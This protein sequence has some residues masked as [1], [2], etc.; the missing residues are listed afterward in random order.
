[1]LTRIL[2]IIT[3]LAGCT[4][5]DKTNIQPGQRIQGLG[6][7][8]EAPSEKSW[9]ASVY[10]TG[11]EIKLNQLNFDD[12]YS[13]LVAMNRGPR[14]GMYKSAEQHLRALKQYHRQTRPPEGFIEKT[15]QEWI[16]SR[17]G[18]ICVRRY[19]IGE[20]WA[21]RNNAGP[22]IVETES[23]ICPHQSLRNVLVTVEL[24][25]RYEAYA[26]TVPLRPL[27]DQLFLS[28]EY[29]SLN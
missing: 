25:R 21:G 14:W 27:A 15:H 26:E 8:F 4:V 6:F 10:G 13:I 3:S 17:F 9:Y 16:D 18:A 22:A 24:S 23:L 12:S 2:L 20:N 5:F 11:N 19:H 7:S 1:M 28:F 29:E